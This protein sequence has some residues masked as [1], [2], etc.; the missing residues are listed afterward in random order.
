MPWMAEL[1][2]LLN[3]DI[4]RLQDLVQRIIEACLNGDDPPGSWSL[5]HSRNRAPAQGAPPSV[6]LFQYVADINA[7]RDDA[8]MA[9]WRPQEVEGYVWEAFSVA[10]TPVPQDKAVTAE[11]LFAQ[12]SHRG[13]PFD[14]YA[15]ALQELEQRGWLQ[16]A[17]PNVYQLAEMGR[18]IRDETER[19][20]DHYFYTPWRSALSEPEI[21]EVHDLMVQL[22]DELQQLTH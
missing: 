7:Y 2:P 3:T 11:S 6:R 13:Y 21:A 10:C 8:H 19:L 5:R 17:E 20:T 9:A 12:L 16:S 22:R 4:V 1:D 14:D 18:A 15:R